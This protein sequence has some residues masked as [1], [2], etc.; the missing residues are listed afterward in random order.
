MFTGSA[1]GGFVDLPVVLDDVDGV[2]VPVGEEGD[3]FVSG[4][5]SHFSAMALK[6]LDEHDNLIGCHVEPNG[7]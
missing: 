4:V 7:E 5:P 6:S 2:T 3:V 1:K